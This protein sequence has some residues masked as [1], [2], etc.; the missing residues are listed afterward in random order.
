MKNGMLATVPFSSNR[1]DSFSKP[2]TLAV[3]MEEKAFRNEIQNEKTNHNDHCGS[4]AA[5][6]VLVIVIISFTQLSE[7][8]NDVTNNGNNKQIK[9][10]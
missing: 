7:Q 3:G 2:L 9:F 8:D 5:A 6:V 1:Q 4:N 10:T